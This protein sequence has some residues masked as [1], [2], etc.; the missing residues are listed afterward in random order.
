VTLQ[1]TRLADATP[2]H[3]PGHTNVQPVQLQGGE[4]SPTV[5]VTVVL[6][7]Y[8]PG[9]RAEEDTMQ[10]ET[11]YVVLAGD[12]FISSDGDETTLHTYDSVRLP[13]GATGALENRGPLPTSILVIRSTHPA[14]R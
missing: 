13:A 14:A 12:L 2:F 8:L 5:D 7:H 3:P 6:S 9:G 11:V 10:S 1:I 4:H